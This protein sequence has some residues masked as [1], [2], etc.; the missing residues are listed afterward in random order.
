M[1]I[2]RDVNEVKTTQRGSCRNKFPSC[3][4]AEPTHRRSPRPVFGKVESDTPQLPLFDA[5][6]LGR[7]AGR[8][9]E[10]CRN[11]QSFD[12]GAA[13]CAIELSTSRPLKKGGFRY[14]F[15]GWMTVYETSL[16]SFQ[17]RRAGWER[18]GDRQLVFGSRQARDLGQRRG[19]A[20]T[21]SRA[22]CNSNSRSRPVRSCEI[23]TCGVLTRKGALHIVLALYL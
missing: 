17:W 10:L 14:S 20:L 11:R 19:I 18:N 7:G 12:E 6:V 16:Q 9:A 15:A 3:C 22:Q 23:S 1:R 13:I 8:T 4:R 5:G 21:R 2:R